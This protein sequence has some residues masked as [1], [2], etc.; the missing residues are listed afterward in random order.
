M[1]IEPLLTLAEAARILNVSDTRTVLKWGRQGRYLLIGSRGAW[2]VNAASLDA[3]TKGQ[4]L[5]HE[6]QRQSSNAD[7]HQEPAQS[8]TAKGGRSRSKQRSQSGMANT[9]TE[10]SVQP[11]RLRRTSIS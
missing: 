7:A 8:A 11:K 1:T 3:Y 5:W 9:D 10:V 2:G 4:S 6:K